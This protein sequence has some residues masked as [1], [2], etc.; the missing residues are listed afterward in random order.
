MVAYYTSNKLLMGTM[1]LLGTFFVLPV[2]AADFDQD[3]LSDH[4]E[5]NVYYTDYQ[6]AD[7]DG[8]GFSDG[9]EVAAG[10]SP[11]MGSSTRMYEFD[12]DG[13]GLNDW[14]EQW[15]GSDIAQADSDGD[16]FSDFDEVMEGYDPD[17]ASPARKF[18][19]S[20]RVLVDRTTQQLGY[21][22]DGIQ[23]VGY[24][25]ST[26]NP[27]TETPEGVFHIER[28]VEIKDYRGADYFVPDVKWNLQFKPMYY[29][30]TAY[31]H[32]DFGKRTHSHG[33]INLRE[34][35]AQL[36]YSYLDVGV[37]IEVVGETPSGYRVGT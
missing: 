35:D 17:D 32:D 9:D 22:V 31:W 14:V 6:R 11:H 8:D 1:I 34:A 4:D 13:D 30:H 18:G 29:M 19:D 15:F 21:Y 26:G 33:C 16:G 2:Q 24:P 37:P 5:I 36:L 3:G 12:Y 10:Y 7:S 27:N 20:R 28:K 23:I 25:V